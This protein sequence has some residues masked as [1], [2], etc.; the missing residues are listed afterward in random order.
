MLGRVQASRLLTIRPIRS[1]FF[2]LSYQENSKERCGGI[3]F[4]DLSQGNAYSF[5]IIFNFK[6]NY[7]LFNFLEQEY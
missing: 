6:N 7:S 4:Y 3:A 5:S 2:L 1:Q